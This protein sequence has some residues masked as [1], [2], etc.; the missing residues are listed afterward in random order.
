VRIDCSKADTVQEFIN[1][2]VHS[3]GFRP[4]FTALNTIFS[5][6]SGFVPAAVTPSVESQLG[7]V[8]H[9]IDRVLSIGTTATLPGV[10]AFDEFDH[11]LK[12]LESETKDE[13][14]KAQV[15]LKLLSQWA[16]ETTKKGTAHVIFCSN[17]VYSEDA[18]RR[19]DGFKSLPVFYLTNVTSGDAT[20]YITEHV[21]EFSKNP[22]C[23]LSFAP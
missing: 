16:N 2:V 4:S 14:R 13:Q 12:L 21:Q 18:L 7:S 9:T 15:F 20:T 1:L 19:Y 8:L 6:F 10:I 22:Q 17:S 23:S 11:F 5:W 3:V